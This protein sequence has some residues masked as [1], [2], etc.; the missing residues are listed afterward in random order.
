MLSLP[1]SW[2]CGY[3]KMH[4]YGPLIIIKQS[5]CNTK[6]FTSELLCALDNLCANEW[7]QCTADLYLSEITDSGLCLWI[8]SVSEF[9]LSWIIEDLFFSSLSYIK[10]STYVSNCYSLSCNA[11]RFFSAS[12]RPELPTHGFLQLLHKLNIYNE[13]LCYFA[14]MCLLGLPL[15]SKYF[16]PFSSKVQWCF[17]DISS[18]KKQQQKNNKYSLCCPT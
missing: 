13:P 10:Y 4:L 18:L 15:H 14:D 9:I 11:L 7:L 12:A 3:S 2:R 8:C 16:Y 17:S 5:F 6:G 1:R